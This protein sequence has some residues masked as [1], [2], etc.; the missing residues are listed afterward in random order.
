MVYIMTERIARKLDFSRKLLLSAAVVLALVIPIGFGVANATPRRGQTQEEAGATATGDKSVSI[1]PH[2]SV[3]GAE[4]HVAIGFSAAGFT[5]R[6]ATLQTIIQT[7]YGVQPDLISGA[8][9]WVNSEKY[10]ID[11]TLPDSAVEDAQKASGGI[12]IERLRLML[13]A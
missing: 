11:V 12:G 9:D 10:D 5:A 3:N 1:R 2:Q 4:D 8:P 6:G 7:A 13:Q